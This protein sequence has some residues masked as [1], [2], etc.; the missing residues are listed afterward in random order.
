MIRI[1]IDDRE[2]RQ[3][4]K[5]LARRVADM[6]PAM[7][8]IGQEMETRIAT[9]FETRR[10]P[11]GRPWA[12]LRPATEKAKKGRGAILYRTGELLDS[13]T[14]RA[15]PFE[16]AVGFGKPYAAYHEFGTRKMP[17]RGLLM[18]DPQAGTLGEEDRRAILEILADYLAEGR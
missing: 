16:V 15:G 6:T 18:A 4:L 9:R 12:P 3:A 14:H 10:D 1:D 17:R 11:A 7:R 2:V 5:Q 8:A 13:R